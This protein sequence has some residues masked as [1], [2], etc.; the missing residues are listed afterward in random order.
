MQLLCSAFLEPQGGAYPRLGSNSRQQNAEITQRGDA[1]G[2]GLTAFA[3]SVED[4]NQDQQK[5]E[6][7]DGGTHRPRGDDPHWDFLWRGR[8]RGSDVTNAFIHYVHNTR[9]STRLLQCDDHGSRAKG[10]PGRAVV[11]GQEVRLH[12]VVDGE[13]GEDAP[14]LG[15]GLAL[16]HCVPLQQRSFLLLPHVLLPGPNLKHGRHRRK[17][18]C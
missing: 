2:K 10:V 12:H 15:G 6:Q 14:A 7:D 11:R 4:E 13:R 8:S 5:D 16:L 1:A 17:N 18:G 9:Q 3:L